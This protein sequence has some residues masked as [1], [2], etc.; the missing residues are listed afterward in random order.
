MKLHTAQTWDEMFGSAEGLVDS[1]FCCY[2]AKS[3][4][5]LIMAS[6]STGVSFP[7]PR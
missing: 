2:A 5:L 6:N 4:A 3:T 7:S 1:G